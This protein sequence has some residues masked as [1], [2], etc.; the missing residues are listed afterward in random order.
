[1]GE[2]AEMNETYTEDHDEQAQEHEEEEE[3]WNEE[4]EQD[5]YTI[6]ER[7]SGEF[8]EMVDNMRTVMIES[9]SD[10]N[11][12]PRTL[13]EVAEDHKQQVRLPAWL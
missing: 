10:E 8:S 2:V 7:E 11:S 1:M 9:S 3:E 4:R 12:L 13:E 5:L 6:A